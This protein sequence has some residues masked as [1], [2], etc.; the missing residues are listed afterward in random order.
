MFTFQKIEYELK[1]EAGT[2]SEADSSGLEVMQ[3]TCDQDLAKVQSLIDE[4]QIL[5]KDI[6]GRLALLKD[7]I[8]LP[9]QVRTF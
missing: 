5:W 1:E 6:N 9:K 8:I 7:S 2:L 4:Y 3:W